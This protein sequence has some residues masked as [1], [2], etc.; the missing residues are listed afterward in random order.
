MKRLWMRLIASTKLQGTC[1]LILNG[2]AIARRGK[3]R[4]IL[5]AEL[6]QFAETQGVDAACIYAVTSPGPGTAN[7]K[8]SIYGIPDSLHQRV[9]NIWSVNS[10]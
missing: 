4:G 8:L 7:F 5:L 3:A 6:S 10:R 1:V 9:R 2:R